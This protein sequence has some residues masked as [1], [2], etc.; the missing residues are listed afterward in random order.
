MHD[1]FIFERNE[2]SISSEASAEAIINLNYASDE[3]SRNLINIEDENKR[4]KSL[5]I[6]NGRFPSSQSILNKMNEDVAILENT[7][8][9]S[10]ELMF[11]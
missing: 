1:L 11:N 9:C 5:S 10:E 8:H 7:V 4:T 3:A 6:I 2:R